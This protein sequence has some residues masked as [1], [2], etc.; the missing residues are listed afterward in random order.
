MFTRCHVT[1]LANIDYYD[2]TYHYTL[3][4]FF[5]KMYGRQYIFNLS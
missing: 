1:N 5:I 2:Y 3:L 4:V